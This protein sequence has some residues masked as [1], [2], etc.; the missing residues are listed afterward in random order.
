VRLAFRPGFARCRDC[1]AAIARARRDDHVCD[2]DRLIEHQL[3]RLRDDLDG[4]EDEIQA[5]L[6]SPRGRFE[7]WWATSERRSCAN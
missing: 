7:S 2:R 4:L 1:G 6:A 5:Y 3:Y